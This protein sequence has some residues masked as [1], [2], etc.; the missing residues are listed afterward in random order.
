LRHY[1][2]GR[3]KMDINEFSREIQVAWQQKYQDATF[4]DSGAIQRLADSSGYD[5]EYCKDVLVGMPE[6]D[7]R[8]A[9]PGFPMFIRYCNEGWNNGKK[10]SHIPS[11][12]YFDSKTGRSY[13]LQIDKNGKRYYNV[14]VATSEFRKMTEKGFQ[15]DPGYI[16]EEGMER[17]EIHERLQK[18]FDHLFE[19]GQIDERNYERGMVGIEILKGNV[20]IDLHFNKQEAELSEIPF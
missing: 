20:D 12:F 15:H 1:Q 8:G 10:Q 17:P 16:I 13:L 11:E 19:S 4:P 14:P 2:H 9:T 7:N 6:K 5:I 18:Q 3:K